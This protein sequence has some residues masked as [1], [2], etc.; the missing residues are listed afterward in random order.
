M[1]KSLKG[2]NG[3]FA[4]LGSVQIQPSLTNVGSE[5]NDPFSVG[6]LPMRQEPLSVPVLLH[7][8]GAVSHVQNPS[9]S[10]LANMAS[11]DPTFVFPL[12]S[13]SNQIVPTNNL[14]LAAGKTYDPRQDQDQTAPRE[15]FHPFELVTGISQERP[16]VI[17]MTNFSPLFERERGPVSSEHTKV[18]LAAGLSEQ[19]TAAGRF[20]DAQFNMR[21]LQSH[22]MQSHVRTL[23]TRYPNVDKMVIERSRGFTETLMRMRD[24]SAFL[25]NAVRMLSDGKSRLDMRND[26]FL[27]K[28]PSSIA[29]YISKN[30]DQLRSPQPA[31]KSVDLVELLMSLGA[32]RSFDFTDCMHDLGYSPSSVRDTFSSTKIW[33]QTL[34]ELKQ[35]LQNHTLA[36]LDVDPLHQRRDNN[37]AGIN[38]APVKY[39]GVAETLP[40]LPDLSTVINLKVGET[41]QAITSIQSAFTSIYQNAFFKNDEA[42]IA[43][44]AHTVSR[45]YR[46][47]R[48]LSIKQV[49]DTLK[50]FYDFRVDPAGNMSLFDSVIGVFGNNINDFSDTSGRSLVSLAQTRPT[51]GVGVLTFETKQVEGDNGTL[52]PGGDYVFDRVMARAT[53]RGFDV[54]GCENLASEAEE[55]LNR[56]LT[57]ID[58]F[59]LMMVPSTADPRR[60]G[61][62]RDVNANFLAHPI[63]LTFELLTGLVNPITGRTLDPVTSDRLGAVYSRA[64][65][66]NRLKTMLF[67][68][69]MSRISRAYTNNVAF[70]SADKSS[71][72]TPLTDYLVDRIVSSLQQSVPETRSAVQLVTQRGLDRG[73]NTSSLT[74]SSVKHSLKSGTA[75]T[76]VVEKF[77]SSVIDWFQNKTS[78]MKDGRTRYG[79]YL[80]TVVMMMA[81][82]LAIAMVARYSNQQL[83]G[84]HRGMSSFSQGQVTFVVTQSSTNHLS[85]VNELV[86]RLN[87]EG[88]LVRQLLVTLTNALLVVGNTSRSTANYFKSVE[89]T[90]KLTDLFNGLGGDIDM[91]RML[92]TEQQAMLLA[93]T[94][95][96][97]VE[98]NIEPVRT[99]SNDRMVM[100]RAPVITEIAVL[101]DSDVPP[102]TQRALFSFFDSPQY[103]A[104]HASNKKIITVGVPL[105]LLQR[106]RQKIGVR[107]QKRATF[108][109][110]RTDII[111]ITVYKVDMQ[112]VDIVFK[113]LRFMFEMSRFPVRYS[114]ARWLDVGDGSTI[115]DVIGAIP[116]RNFDQGTASSRRSPVQFNL[117]YSSTVIANQQGV[118]SARA[119]FDDDS[120]SFLTSGQKAQILHN[121]VVSQ[122]LDVYIKMM[123][124]IDVSEDNYH[125]IDPPSLIDPAVATQLMRHSLANLAEHA[126]TQSKAS[127]GSSPAGGV[128]FSP[129]AAVAT[130]HVKKKPP[131]IVDQVM[132]NA[133]GTAGNM[134][135]AAQFNGSLSLGKK[136]VTLE[137]QA[138]VASSEA[139]LDALG[140]KH[141]SAAVMTMRTASRLSMTASPFAS[142][143]AW[144]KKVLLPKQFDR[145]FNVI[146]DPRD[147]DIDMQKTLATPYGKQALDLLIQHGEVV[148]SGP[149]FHL[150]QFGAKQWGALVAGPPQPGPSSI[151]GPGSSSGGS[152][153]FRTRDKNAGDLV[154]DKY[155]VT[156]ETLDEGDER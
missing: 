113:P 137:Q 138:A 18:L 35:A 118:K 99:R 119:A 154:A 71:D 151:E 86:Q 142:I 66:D 84:A 95:E 63:D 74:P 147:F 146:I 132:S 21:S 48:G 97:L 58:G 88:S 53:S 31:N 3:S 102:E 32:R 145:V 2:N 15:Q 79:G 25:L 20:L 70:L 27:V 61:A 109:D 80:D 82:D 11:T 26:A 30:F 73:L 22:H 122:L 89:A 140:H 136:S 49:Q 103:A 107:D 128:V 112:N 7:T 23:R 96:S 75:L 77:M 52:S 92:L 14:S 16:E 76:T 90:S 134:D 93:S 40:S 101:D 155:F 60:P 68:H 135:A 125:I 129:T 111:Q 42:R 121:H 12:G 19:Q 153:R 39:F 144:R 13:H 36:L 131:G 51:D 45:E 115:N 148:P 81:F 29:R 5:P 133:A 4:G 41:A 139:S 24:D 6:S 110:R 64:R 33:M 117:E 72:N 108:N 87:K 120:Y 127:I 98:A 65:S 100:T 69:T 149:E 116:T 59:N 57:V 10:E 106:M 28:D 43:A 114:S 85:S 67:M 91:L 54:Q 38:K 78:A 150:K 56:L 46:Y 47:S 152:F 124:G 55:Q 34:Y 156:I 130:S 94:V 104:Q 143:A 83:V 105:G 126:A 44:L 141:V 62:G 123:T 50:R 17:M 37:P 1:I 9:L 8:S